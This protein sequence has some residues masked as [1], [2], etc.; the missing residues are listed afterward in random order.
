[1]YPF[2]KLAKTMFLKILF[3]LQNKNLF[4][5]LFVLRTKPLVVSVE[6]PYLYQVF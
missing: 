4:A 6:F 3:K 1:M 5:V 2:Y